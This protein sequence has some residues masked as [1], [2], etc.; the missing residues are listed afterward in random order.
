MDIVGC[1]VLVVALIGWIVQ[2]LDKASRRGK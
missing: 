2:E 1:L